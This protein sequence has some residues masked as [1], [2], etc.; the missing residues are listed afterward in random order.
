MFLRWMTA[1]AIPYNTLDHWAFHE[2]RAGLSL[3]KAI[4]RNAAAGFLANESA[5]MLSWLREQLADARHVCLIIDN[6]YRTRRGVNMFGVMARWHEGV[7]D[8]T[9]L[10]RNRP[11]IGRLRHALLAFAGHPVGESSNKINQRAMIKR[12]INLYGLGD[13][14]TAIASDHGSDVANLLD[15]SVVWI[16][17]GAH[18][19]HLIVKHFAAIPV[20]EA[21]L[22]RA[23]ALALWVRTHSPVWQRVWSFR[24]ASRA[25]KG[26]DESAISSSAPSVHLVAATR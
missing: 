4:N 20:V 15:D 9:A 12:V 5:I 17:C 13:K 19:I 24:K 2:L 22:G 25:A 3:P 8:A 26:L 10:N 21:L 1:A 18:V 16:G 11:P 14:I 23:R 7:P 6:Y